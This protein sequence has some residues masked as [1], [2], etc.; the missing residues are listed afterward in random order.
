MTRT[1]VITGASRGIG[2]AI[3]TR[4]ADDGWRTINLDIAPPADGDADNWI[5]TDLSDPASITAAFQKARDQG[6]ITG[7][8]N[9]AAIALVDTL[10][11][12]SIDDFD[13]TMAIN[14][15]APM[16]CAQAV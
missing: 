5:E 1:A 8:V 14:L 6:P 7:L 12:S 3:S 4:L 13:R 10:E 9:N 15:R 16:L 2:K 11:E